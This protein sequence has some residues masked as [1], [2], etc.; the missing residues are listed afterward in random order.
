VRQGSLA[1]EFTTRNTFTDQ[2]RITMQLLR[3][4]FR[5]LDG[6]WLMT[7]IP[8][9]GC[10]IELTMRFAFGNP[11]TAMLFESKFAHTVG[12]LVDAFVARARASR[13]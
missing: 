2:H 4:P 3:G 12:S 7:G 6:E 13:P 9:G 5:Q 10:R 1:G 11:L 8:G